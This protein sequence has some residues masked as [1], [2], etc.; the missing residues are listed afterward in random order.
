MRENMTFGLRATPVYGR[1]MGG[2][3]STESA[4]SKMSTKLFE[5]PAP[6]AANNEAQGAQ[7]APQNEHAANEHVQQSLIHRPS[8][9]RERVH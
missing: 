4:K 9:L 5:E 1:V 7:E 8:F 3:L 6:A 2:C